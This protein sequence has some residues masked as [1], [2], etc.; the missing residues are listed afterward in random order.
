MH[1]Y[2]VEKNYLYPSA[3]P[4]TRHKETTIPVMKKKFLECMPLDDNVYD[5]L[6]NL[7]IPKLCIRMNTLKVSEYNDLLMANFFCCKN[8]YILSSCARSFKMDHV[9]ISTKKLKS[10]IVRERGRSEMC[11]VTIVHKVFD[12]TMIFFCWIDINIY[13]YI[14]FFFSFGQN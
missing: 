1:L 12:E 2:A 5:K 3:P 9:I 11:T 13:V 14:I 10:L 4:L 6:N 8:R 7:T